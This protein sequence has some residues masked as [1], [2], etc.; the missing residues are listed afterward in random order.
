MEKKLSEL[1]EPI[2]AIQNRSGDANP[3]VS[4]IIFDSRQA[5]PGKMFVA[6]RGSATDGHLY[7]SKAVDAGVEV[8][9]CE[10]MPESLK[11]SVVYIQ[12][13]DSS[14]VLGE[15]ASAFYGYPSRQ[16]KLVGVTG[17]NGKTTIA[18]LLYRLTT[19]LGHKT[20]LFSTVANYIVDRKIDSTHTTPDAVSLNKLM[21]EMVAAGCDY[22]FMEVSS[23][24]VDQQ[25]IAGLVFAE[26]YLRI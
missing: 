23:H 24:S 26:V 20:G 13:E 9:I 7:I 18:T 22:C 3:M 14:K 4:D 19:Q 12:V 2:K 15:V 8:V 11:A 6:T 17:T 21:A 25:R 10:Q 5:A 16:L 1:L